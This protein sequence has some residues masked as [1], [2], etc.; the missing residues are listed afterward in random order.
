MQDNHTGRIPRGGL[1][2][3]VTAGDAWLEMSVSHFKDDMFTF[4]VGDARRYTV[5]VSPVRFCALGHIPWMR[6]SNLRR[7]PQSPE[8]SRVRELRQG[9]CLIIGEPLK[10]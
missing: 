3:E 2:Y 7:T 4:H 1:R 5:L 8:W 9:L 10:S 6:V